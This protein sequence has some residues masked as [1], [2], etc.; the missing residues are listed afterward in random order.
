MCGLHWVMKSPAKA[1]LDLS[2][3]DDDTPGAVSLFEGVVTAIS[4][5][6]TLFGWASGSSDGLHLLV[7]LGIGR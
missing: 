7:L 6:S 1:M 4:S 3:L 5:P 2:G